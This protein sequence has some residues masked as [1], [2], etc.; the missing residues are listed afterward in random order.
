M[1]FI[2]LSCYYT[3]GQ[4][5]DGVECACGFNKAHNRSESRLSQ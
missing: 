4:T 2:T 3:E 5:G 1:H